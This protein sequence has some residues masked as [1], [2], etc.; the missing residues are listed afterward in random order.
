MNDE[1]ASNAKYL[2]LTN[3]LGRWDH[4]LAMAQK[5]TRQEVLL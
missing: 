5:R 4:Y 1:L 3:L 2:R